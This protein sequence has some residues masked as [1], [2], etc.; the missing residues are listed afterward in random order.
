VMF[1][2]IVRVA[3]PTFFAQFNYLAVLAG[4]AW[5]MLVL[6][7]RLSVY[8]FVAMLLMFVG[9]SLSARRASASAAAAPGSTPI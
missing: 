9:V 3:G 7:E 6:G 1:F 2:E 8:F 5:S 4:L